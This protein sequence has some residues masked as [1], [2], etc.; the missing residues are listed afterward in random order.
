MLL[1]ISHNSNRQAVKGAA[2][3]HAQS[4]QQQRAARLQEVCAA[5]W[6]SILSAIPYVVFGHASSATTGSL[7]IYQHLSVGSYSAPFW[8][9]YLVT[10]TLIPKTVFCKNTMNNFIRFQYF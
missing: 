2:S 3:I 9:I 10:A 7:N 6:H 1:L 5:A 4:Q 8:K